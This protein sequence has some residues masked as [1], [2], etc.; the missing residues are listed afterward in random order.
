MWDF[1]R[2]IVPRL[3]VTVCADPDD[4]RTLECALEADAQLI[5]TGDADLA[6][7]EPFRGFRYP[8]SGGFPSAIR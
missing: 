1:A 2:N 5:V 6:E 7:I 4:N 3:S 8:D